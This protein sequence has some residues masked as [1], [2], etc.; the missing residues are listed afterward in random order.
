MNNLKIVFFGSSQFSTYVLDELKETGY[1]PILNI[2]NARED[3]DVEKLRKL[4]ADIFVVASFG[5]ILSREIIELPKNK[6]LNIHPSLLPISRGPAPIQDTIL[7]DHP[8]G[9]TII[10][11]D[12][13]MDHGPIIA[14][15]SIDIEPWPDHYSTVEEKLG[16]AGGK[17]LAEVLPLWVKGEIEEKPQE[18][19]VTYTKLIKKEDG[20]IDLKDPVEKNWRKVLAYSTWPCAYF[21]FE[22][23]QGDK[24]RVVVKEAKIVDGVF[25]PVR[26]IPE[27]KKEM[28]WE[29]FLKGNS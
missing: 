18:D 26:V 17:L 11:M 15:E 10:R 14:Q 23:K 8:R 2:T 1:S 24:K 4:E 7:Q 27:G 5:K 3:I 19:E 21:F 28:S 29:D 6:T 9:V 20:L 13:K 12:E 22:R 16:H 25:T